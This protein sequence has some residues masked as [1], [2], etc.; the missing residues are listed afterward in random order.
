LA[1]PSA[2]LLV[3]GRP[4]LC[5]LVSLLFCL[6][7]WRYSWRNVPLNAL[8]VLVYLCTLTLEWQQFGLPDPPVT[9]SSNGAPRKGFVFGLFLYSTPT[10]YVCLRAL[11]LLPLLLILRASRKLPA[12]QLLKAAP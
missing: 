4:Q 2:Q 9:L 11:L 5:L 12:N 3:W 7:Y 1:P 10:V 8:V 6:L